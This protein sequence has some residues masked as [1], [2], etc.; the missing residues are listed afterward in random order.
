[1]R[2]EGS[3]RTIN[4]HAT[5]F[6]A[7]GPVGTPVGQPPRPTQKMLD[8]ALFLDSGKSRS[9]QMDKLLAWWALSPPWGCFWPRVGLMRVDGRGSGRRPSAG[10][11]WNLSPAAWKLCDAGTLCPSLKIRA[12]T[13]V[14]SESEVA[15]SCPT[16]W[17]PMDCSLSGS[18]VHGIFQARVL[19]RIAISFSRGSSRPRDQI[20]VFCL[21]G[22]FFTI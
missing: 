13:K 2:C 11:C 5:C 18:S 20:W 9:H 10:L 16:L 12:L 21:A 6:L 22:R 14:K 7:G 19:E 3:A 4:R 17:D 1:M 8:G 15:Q